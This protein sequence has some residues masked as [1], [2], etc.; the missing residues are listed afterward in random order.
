[1][2]NA[3]QEAALIEWFQKAFK[4][5]GIDR[6]EQAINKLDGLVDGFLL[7]PVRGMIGNSLHLHYK[8]MTPHL[9]KNRRM[10]LSKTG[11][12]QTTRTPPGFS[13]HP[14]PC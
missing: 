11:E 5:F 1:M 6:G 7:I 14:S 10:R 12:Q 13:F 9:R 8:K 4:L 2:D 3:H